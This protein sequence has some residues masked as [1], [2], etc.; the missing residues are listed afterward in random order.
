[1]AKYSIKL[2]TTYVDIK[3]S[4][5]FV[6]KGWV[7]ISISKD[8]IYIYISR[9]NNRIYW[10]GSKKG[11]SAK[12]SIKFND[13]KKMITINNS[14][15]IFFHNSKD[16]DIIKKKTIFYKHMKEDENSVVFQERSGR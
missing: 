15:K 16:Y 13:N 14:N 4:K 6:K 11:Y 8:G 5:G 12:L 3:N 2:T 7:N 10:I 9:D 1:M